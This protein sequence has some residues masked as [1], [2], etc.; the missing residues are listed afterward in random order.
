M[1]LQN[2]RRCLRVADEIG[3]VM[4]VIEAKNDRAAAWYQSDG[5]IPLDDLAKTLVMPLATIRQALK[6]ASLPEK[7]LRPAPFPPPIFFKF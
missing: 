1:A 6:A 5:A 4:L 2:D 3:G 7:V